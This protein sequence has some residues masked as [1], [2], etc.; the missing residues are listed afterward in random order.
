APERVRLP[1]RIWSNT[2]PAR[3]AAKIQT[4]IV[5]VRFVGGPVWLA[6]DSRA[7]L[8][9]VAPDLADRLPAQPAPEAEPTPEPPVHEPTSEPP[10]QSETPSPS[11]VPRP[12]VVVPA[13]PPVP[14][15]SS[16]LRPH[17]IDPRFEVV[18]P[19]VIRHFDDAPA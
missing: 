17:V 18:Q 3:A 12:P 15:P 2:V 16:L 14:P 10:V 13:T 11:F 5:G 9:Q 1:R 4:T 6:V 7:D 19:V 8:E